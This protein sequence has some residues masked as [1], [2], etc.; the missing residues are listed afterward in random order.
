MR[1]KALTLG[2]C[3]VVGLGVVSCNDATEDMQVFEATLSPQNEIPPRP[4]AA[5]GKAQFLWD[6]TTMRFTIEIDD[7]Q[8][9]VQG[10]IHIGSSTV[11]GPVRVWLYQLPNKAP[12]PPVSTTDKVARF[13]GTFTAADVI[14]PTT[15]PDLLAAMANGGAYANLHTSQ[16]PGGEMRGQINQV[17]VN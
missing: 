1:G 7:I 3:L 12:G 17:T 6:G 13:E 14:A 10:H 5:S 8:N 11:N 15:M 2:L 16:F 9:I 4:S